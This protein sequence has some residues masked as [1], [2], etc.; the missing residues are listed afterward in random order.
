[1]HDVLVIG[2][3]PAGISAALWCE[4]LG[5]DVLLLDQAEEVGG[6]LLQVHNSIT[7]YPG[8]EFGS[9]A[10]LAQKLAE[11]VNA[12][13]F[14]L[15]T[16]IEIDRIDL[17]TKKVYLKSGEELHSIS[18]VLATGLR[19]RELGIPGERE[20]A[21]SGII[22][23]GARDAE[24][25]AGKDVC[26]IGGGDAAAE[27]ALLLAQYC[28]TV[29][30]VHRGKQLKARSGFT[31]QLQS[32]HCITV[33]PES[34]VTRILGDEKVE[35]VEVKRQEGIKPF[36]MAVQGVLIRIGMK[37]NTELFREQVNTDAQG[38]ILI[39]SQ[40]ETSIPNVFAVG[41]ISNPLAPT[42]A[43][44]VGD[45]ATAAKVISSRLTNR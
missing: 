39:T 26:I 6:Q 4:E 40:Q 25:L 5:L 9:G 19:R 21:G 8:V 22:E 20:F 28:A 41:D 43:G 2:A 42:I 38:Y 34:I 18:I 17:R 10:Q 31:S 30:L 12:A 35:A 11:Q 13:E 3:G 24:K 32:N 45:G 16:S 29:T 14:D 23:S 15:W 44:A 36:Q 37:P 27:N 1:M 33:F 7:N